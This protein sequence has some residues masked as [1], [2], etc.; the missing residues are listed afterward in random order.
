ML[1]KHNSAL[2]V[3]EPMEQVS[4]TSSM[5]CWGFFCYVF[6][7]AL[8]LLTMEEQRKGESEKSEETKCKNLPCG[9]ESRQTGCL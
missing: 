2:Y 3:N 4:Y 9:T 1:H 5:F 6:C 8:G 7:L